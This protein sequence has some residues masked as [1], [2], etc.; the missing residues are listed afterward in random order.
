M[1]EEALGYVFKD[2][3]LSRRCNLCL[4]DKLAIVQADK[5]RSLNKRSEL[6]SK[7]RH[8]NKIYPRN[9]APTIK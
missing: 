1:S 7:G 6:V 2:A 9:F 3:V 5:L 8:E 4:A